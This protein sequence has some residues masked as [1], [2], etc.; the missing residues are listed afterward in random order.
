MD[1]LNSRWPLCLWL[2]GTGPIGRVKRMNEYQYK[3]KNANE[4]W[5]EAVLKDREPD[6]LHEIIGSVPEITTYG[7]LETMTWEWELVERR[8]SSGTATDSLK[9]DWFDYHDNYEAALKPCPNLIHTD[10]NGRK[11]MGMTKAELVQMPSG[12]HRNIFSDNAGSVHKLSFQL[13]ETKKG[14]F[15][16]VVCSVCG[17][18]VERAGRPILKTQAE[19]KRY[20][21]KQSTRFSVIYTDWNGTERTGSFKSFYQAY[22]YAIGKPAHIQQQREPIRRT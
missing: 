3:I 12:H 14:A 13:I 21:N 19:L 11:S 17:V 2:S 9:S 15:Q 4:R 10:N 1:T 6:M 20:R 18:V 22:N 8:W 7:G 5:D 16:Q